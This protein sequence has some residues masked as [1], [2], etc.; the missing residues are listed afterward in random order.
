[1]VNPTQSYPGCGDPLGG[2]TESKIPQLHLPA[3][4]S[5]VSQSAPAM[6]VPIAPMIEDMQVA[7]GCDPVDATLLKIPG[8]P[9]LSIE[10]GQR[11]GLPND[12]VPNR[13]VDEYAQSDQRGIDEWV[14]NALNEEQGPDCV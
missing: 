1:M 14:G 8:P 4:T 12:N 13:S 11:L 3:G 2:S 7:V 6:R 5:N 10:L 9:S